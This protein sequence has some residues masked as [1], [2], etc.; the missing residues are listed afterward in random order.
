MVAGRS[1]D[2]LAE[3]P[4]PKPLW[5][6]ARRAVVRSASAAHDHWLIRRDGT[7]RR[8]ASAYELP[9]GSRR[10][11]CYHVRKTAGTS[12]FLSF[13]ALG[14]E[15]PFAV[16]GRINRA[17]LKRTTSGPYAFASDNRRV[18]AEGAYL[19]GRSHRRASDQPLPSRTY[20]VT[21]LRDPA[22]R[23]HSLYDYLVA[24]DEPG[25]PGRVSARDRRLA[26]GGFDAFLDR[27][28]RHYLLTQLAMFS[29]RLDVGEAAD[30]IAA[31]SFV[32][33][34]ARFAD[35]LAELGRRLDLDLE[36]QRA[37]VTAQHSE[38]SEAQRERLRE[39][40]APE[41]ELLRRLEA[42]GVT[43]GPGRAS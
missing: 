43:G 40:L 24:G 2:G 23:V 13:L 17:R 30:R 3:G 32:F 29:D 14:G 37:R 9:D 36:P 42:A 12:L 20:T 35:G 10:V 22:E 19:F 18:L 27:I 28:P 33:T 39:R 31:C 41:Y 15:D 7:Y 16:W 8:L 26:L 34:T 4:A 11:Y 25:L 21:V 6:R 38:L 1:L 5:R